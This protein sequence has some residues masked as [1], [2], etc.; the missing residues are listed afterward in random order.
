MRDYFLFKID[1]D[2]LILF[3]LFMQY[4]LLTDTR[5]GVSKQQTRDQVVLINPVQVFPNK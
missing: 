4:G 2:Q 3:E 1:G 5:V